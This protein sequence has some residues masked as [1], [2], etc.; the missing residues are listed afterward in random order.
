MHAL[1]VRG[2]A[3]LR[4][5]PVR[6]DNDPLLFRL[7]EPQAVHT[8]TV[9]ALARH[10]PNNNRLVHEVP[11]IKSYDLFRHAHLPHSMGGH[12]ATE[13]SS[14]NKENTD[15]IIN[16]ATV[17]LG[18]PTLAQLARNLP[19]GIP[20]GIFNEFIPGIFE[21]YLEVSAVNLASSVK[22]F[23][24]NPIRTI[25]EAMSCLTA[26]LRPAIRRLG[27]SGVKTAFIGFER[28]CLIPPNDEI[29]N[30]VDRFSVI[31]RLGHM[32]P[33]VKPNEVANQIVKTIEDFGLAAA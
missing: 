18:S 5:D 19:A 25:S 21:G 32:A 10:V 28:D 23:F 3:T 30:D 8:D 22:Y 31:P 2:V 9:T 24:H 13:H 26:D 17:G 27:E 29:A 4:Y 1:A 6:R 12:P 15:V 20:R 14:T 11:E 16:L 33:Q 7:L